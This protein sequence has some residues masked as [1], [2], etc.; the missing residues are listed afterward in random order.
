MKLDQVIAPG[1]ETDIALPVRFSELPGVIIDNPFL[2][3]VVREA[4][5]WRFLARVP[6]TAGPRGEPIAGASV[7]MTSQRVGT[8]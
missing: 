7:V 3:L 8:H 1:A 5:D 2:I 4:E 6:V